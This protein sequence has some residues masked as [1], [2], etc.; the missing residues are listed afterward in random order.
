[1]SP[2]QLVPEGLEPYAYD[3]AKAKALL[4]EAG[5][6][7]INGDKPIT[8]LTYY[9]TPQAANV[10]AAI[11]AM[12]AQVGI[13]VVPR[14]V[15]TPTYN[16]IVYKRRHAR[17]ER[18][19]RWSMPACRTGPIPAR[20]TRSQRGADPAGRH[21]HHAHRIPELT[22]A[23]DAALGETDAAK[24]DRSW[25]DVC[26]VMNKNLPWGDLVGRQ[27]LWRR[28]DRARGLRLDAGAGRRSLRRPSR[29]RWDIQ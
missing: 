23:F 14:A 12:L 24:L 19:F 22:P 29:E 9:N 6:D 13:N 4:A 2:P 3:P 20:S 21:Q 7:K 1:M 25:Q 16:G 11:Q 26:K 18:S 27:P 10:M 28:L 15:D 8:W 17:L 5:W